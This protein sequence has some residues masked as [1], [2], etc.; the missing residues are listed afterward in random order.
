MNG[1]ELIALGIGDVPA[2]L[3]DEGL[4]LALTYF[5]DNDLNPHDCFKAKE[6]DDNHEL[7]RHW[8]KAQHLANTVLHGGSKYI[9]S[10]ISL[11]YDFY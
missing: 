6:T 5:S 7:A 4:E 2:W 9:N 3:A 1:K 11:D 8:Y 10:V